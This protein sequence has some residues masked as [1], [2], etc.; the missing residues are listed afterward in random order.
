MSARARTYKPWM[1]NCLRR[2]QS[3]SE[4]SRNARLPPGSYHLSTSAILFQWVS[5]HK[6]DNF[7]HWDYQPINIRYIFFSCYLHSTLNVCC[8]HSIYSLHNCY[9]QNILNRRAPA[10][11]Y[12]HT[13]SSGGL[14]PL[15]SQQ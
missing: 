8:N 6:D 1:G 2:L 15:P 4:R 5:I 9:Q 14:W 11:K 7:I 12:D 10:M 3:Y 13:A